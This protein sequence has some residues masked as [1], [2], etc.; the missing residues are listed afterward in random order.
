MV[1]RTPGPEDLV[2]PVPVAWRVWFGLLGA[3]AAWA[4]HFLAAYGLMEVGCAGGWEQRAISGLNGVA[5][6]VLVVTLLTMPVIVGAGLVAHR[7][8]RGA[9]D[10]APRDGATANP[11]THVGQAGLFLSGFFLLAII[12]EAT[13]ALV[14]PPCG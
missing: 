5:V 6:A 11:Q 3:P 14:L 9:R 13:P 1:E 8:S 4:A 7:L 10:G 12:F 2:R